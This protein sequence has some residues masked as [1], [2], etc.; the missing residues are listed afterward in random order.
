MQLI[1]AVPAPVTAE[2]VIGSHDKPDGTVTLRLTEVE[3][4]FSGM[5]VIVAFA[6]WPASDRP[7]ENA[8][9]VKSWNENVT[10]VEWDSGVL[11]LVIVRL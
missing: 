5:I 2:G 6:C 4:P 10:I 1:V 3:N 7:G 11:V 8:T 9:I